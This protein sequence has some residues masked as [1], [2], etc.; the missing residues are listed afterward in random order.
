MRVILDPAFTMEHQISAVIKSVFCQLWQTVRLH[1]FLDGKPL[2]M[3]VH[4][5]VLSQ[6]NCWN[7]LYLGLPLKLAQVQKA[8][9]RLIT[10][11]RKFDDIFPV[12]AQLH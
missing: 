9:A 1:P 4:A 11:G 10:G 8:A 2:T 6:I 12:L 7:A 3:L 5:L